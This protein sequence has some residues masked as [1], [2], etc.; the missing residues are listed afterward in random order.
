VQLRPRRYI[1]RSAQ[2]KFIAQIREIS[3]LRESSSPSPSPSSPSPSPRASS[4]RR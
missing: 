4:R 2:Q 3:G 1:L